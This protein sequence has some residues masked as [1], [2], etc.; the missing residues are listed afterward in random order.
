MVEFL[1]FVFSGFWMWLG[2]FLILSLLTNFVVRMFKVALAQGNI[3]RHGYPPGHCDANG[4]FP[5]IDEEEE[6]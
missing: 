5:K 3:R 1:K 4:E 2:F 6:N